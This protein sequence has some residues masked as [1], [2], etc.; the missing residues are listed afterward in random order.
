V[1][2]DIPTTYCVNPAL[3]RDPLHAIIFCILLV[4]ISRNIHWFIMR[5]IKFAIFGSVDLHNT[6]YF[7]CGKFKLQYTLW[8]YEYV[9]SHPPLQISYGNKN[10]PSSWQVFLHNVCFIYLTQ[11]LQSNN[12]AWHDNPG[13]WKNYGAALSLF[14]LQPDGQVKSAAELIILSETGAMRLCKHSQE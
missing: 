1:A 14:L 10:M 4:W 9:D 3:R 8:C 7:S 5:H 12:H 11:L 2:W 6:K 13:A